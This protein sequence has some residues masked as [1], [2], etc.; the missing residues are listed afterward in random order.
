MKNADLT[1]NNYIK[2]SIKKTD[3]ESA[4]AAL[5]QV[6]HLLPDYVIKKLAKRRKKEGCI[7]NSVRLYPEP[8]LNYNNENNHLKNLVKWGWTY[9]VILE[10]IATIYQKNKNS[11]CHRFLEKALLRYIPDYQK[12]L[13]NEYRTADPLAGA[14]LGDD[15]IKGKSI[16]WNLGSVGGLDEGDY[17]T[18]MLKKKGLNH[19]ISV[20]LDPV[21]I[22]HKTLLCSLESFCTA[23]SYI[24]NRSPLIAFVAI[25]DIYG[26]TIRMCNMLEQKGARTYFCFDKE[27]KYT[28]GSLI[29]KHGEKIDILFL[30]A[31]IE[32]LNRDSPIITALSQNA[33]ALDTSP[34]ARIILRSKV[35]LA[36]LGKKECLDELDLSPVEKTMLKKHIVPTFVWSKDMFSLKHFNSKIAVKLAIGPV[37]GGTDVNIVEKEQ[38]QKTVKKHI[39]PFALESLCLDTEYLYEMV[40]NNI[41]AFL[42]DAILKSMVS[43]II[44][45]DKS[46][47]KKVQQQV[48]L[49]FK[50]QMT[51][52]KIADIFKNVNEQLGQ[53]KKISYQKIAL[54]FSSEIESFFRLTG[55]SENIE[56]NVQKILKMLQKPFI[57]KQLLKRSPVVLQP[58]IEPENVCGHD[59]LF[60]INRIHVFYTNGGKQV[61]VA[62]S[63]VFKLKNHQH[64]NASKC[65]ACLHIN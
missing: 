10:K 23:N 57:Q 1:M 4:E 17:V 16:E 28:N 33:V 52:T 7:I 53:S 5:K 14:H 39:I 18:K 31:H 19:E 64:D 41:S 11:F 2:M 26:S 54:L 58:W 25:Y 6:S 24:K 37:F 22:F 27:L 35:I 13:I 44:Q 65:T 60:F 9:S 56:S 15:N 45:P 62:G 46:D 42:K 40:R 48:R 30:D 59:D 32:S 36:L 3:L 49:E 50:K 61:L 34:F 8:V 63:Q 12:N 29:T 21:E 55:F 47:K 51:G 43:K 38:V 20:E